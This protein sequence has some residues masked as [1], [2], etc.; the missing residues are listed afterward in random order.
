MQIPLSFKLSPFT[1]KTAFCF[2]FFVLSFTI[3]CGINPDLQG[4]GE[5]Y[6]Q[7]EW[8]QDSLPMQKK[9]L[10]YS[11]YHLKFNCD[12]FYMQINSFSK[13]NNGADTCM[14]S[15][16]WTEYVKG[17]YQQRNDTLHLRGQFCNANY[18][19]KNEGGCFRSG[20]YQEFFKVSKKTDSLVQFSSISNVI[21]INAHLIKRSTC[22]PKPL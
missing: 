10:D 17:S 4:K 3:G 19:L 15:G 8:Q 6:L 18:S 20:I 2:L 16:R 12:S 9:L 22:N 7:G 5:V 1:S 21:P 14:N 11:I 13:V